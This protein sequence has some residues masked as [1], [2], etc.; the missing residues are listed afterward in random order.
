MS[1]IRLLSIGEMMLIRKERIA[2]EEYLFQ[3][4]FHCHI[5]TWIG[6]GYSLCRVLRGRQLTTSVMARTRMKIGLGFIDPTLNLDTGVLI[7][8]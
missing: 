3:Y 4:Q 2:L 6:L 5:D 7:S 1:E 8:P